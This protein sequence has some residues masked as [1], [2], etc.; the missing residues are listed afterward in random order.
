MALKAAKTMWRIMLFV[1]MGIKKNRANNNEKEVLQRQT[2]KCFT[3]NRIEAQALPKVSPLL[4]L[5]G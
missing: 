2:G 1:A 4:S 3:T 5:W